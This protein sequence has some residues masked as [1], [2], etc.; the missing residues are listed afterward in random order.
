MQKGA[1]KAVGDE[2]E[3]C[4]RRYQVVLFLQKGADKAEGDEPERR[5]LVQLLAEL[6]LTNA[7]MVHGLAKFLHIFL[8]SKLPAVL[9][10]G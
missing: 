2:L 9:Q 1:D 7:V 10:N 4:G 6:R 5:I 8:G 3:R